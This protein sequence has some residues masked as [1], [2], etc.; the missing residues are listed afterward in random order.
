LVP[1]LGLCF[2]DSGFFDRKPSFSRSCSQVFDSGYLN[3]QGFNVMR[4]DS[5]YHHIFV[6]Q[7]N[8]AIEMILHGERIATNG[9]VRLMP[10]PGQWDLVA[11][12]KAP[13]S[14]ALAI[15][16][17]AVSGANS[18]Q[19]SQTNNCP[20]SLAAGGNCT[21]SVMFAP[22]A[23]G[24]AV[25]ALSITD[26][27]LGSPQTVSLLGTG[28][29]PTVVLSPT[30]LTFASQ[31]VGLPARRRLS[32]SPT[33]AVKLSLSLRLLPAQLTPRPTTA[34][35]RLQPAQL[36]ALPSSSNRQQPARRRGA[37]L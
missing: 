32:R 28:V 5:V 37:L 19:Y 14:A 27:A 21:I 29:A 31:T 26:G 22:T 34:D 24:T 18:S 3:T 2:L 23:S 35:P 1:L 11:Q 16:S 13:G 8:T 6:D 9:D 15:T 30:S 17:I 36:A 12:L 7:K 25:A 33:R 20:N 4:Y 10:T